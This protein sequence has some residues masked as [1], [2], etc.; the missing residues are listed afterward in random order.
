MRSC[1]EGVA[2]ADTRLPW[3]RVPEIV[4]LALCSVIVVL[5]SGERCLMM[6]PA[7]SFA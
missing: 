7:V 3:Q 6:H 1:L 4:S 5:E 2:V